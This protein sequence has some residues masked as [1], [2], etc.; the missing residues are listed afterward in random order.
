MGERLL[1]VCELRRRHCETA[2]FHRGPDLRHQRAHLA[3]RPPVA[4]ARRSPSGR[5][6][7]ARDASS[8]SPDAALPPSGQTARRASGPRQF[9][10]ER[11]LTGGSQLRSDFPDAGLQRSIRI[12]PK[13]GKRSVHAAQQHQPQLCGGRQVARMPR[14]CRDARA[15]PDRAPARAGSRGSGT[16][17]PALPAQPASSRRAPAGESRA[18]LG[19]PA[20]AVTKL[21]ALNLPAP[22]K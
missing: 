13:R 10:A 16:R 5:Q 18:R 19:L 9:L 21:L 11:R 3:S 4:A 8:V 1:P 12:I 15:L 2:P 14:P 6:P 7:A 20:L 17:P 22:L